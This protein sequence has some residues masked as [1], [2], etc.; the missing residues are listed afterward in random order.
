MG[1]GEA[2]IVVVVLTVVLVRAGAARGEMCFSSWRRNSL[3][4]D[5]SWRT[6]FRTRS[7]GEV[8]VS[9][10]SCVRL[11]WESSKGSNVP[12]G[13]LVGVRGGEMVNTFVVVHGK[14]WQC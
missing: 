2:L 6:S 5:R 11:T 7:I 12:E 9:F 10:I 14:G 1:E 4:S 8:C 3:T 13:S